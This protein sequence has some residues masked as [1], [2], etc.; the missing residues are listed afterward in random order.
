MPQLC[1][2]NPSPHLSRYHLVSTMILAPLHPASLATGTM[3]PMSSKKKK[4]KH[5]KRF[6]GLA[7]VGPNPGPRN[8]SVTSRGSSVLTAACTKTHA[9]ARCSVKIHT[10]RSP[11]HQ[12]APRTSRQMRARHAPDKIPEHLQQLCL[13]PVRAVAVFGRGAW[14]RERD[15]RT[16][17]RIA[18]RRKKKAN[19]P[20]KPRAKPHPERQRVRSRFVLT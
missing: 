1:F 14:A 10:R 16:Q 13:S 3:S 4:K 11:R 7:W 18:S 12:R 19:T 17:K 9:G 5:P 15:T 2:G 20:N 8:A 6:P